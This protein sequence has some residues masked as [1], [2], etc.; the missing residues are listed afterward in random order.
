M[1]SNL[2]RIFFEWALIASVLM[3]LGF[4][5][6]YYMRSHAARGYE[7]QIAAAQ[8]HLQNERNFL[9]GLGNDCNLYA[10][11]NVDMQRFLASLNQPV[12]A[13]ANKPATTR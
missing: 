7:N 2:L 10:K 13:P 9:V 11:T 5:I 8:V 1:K 3:S 12:S 6:W 4:F